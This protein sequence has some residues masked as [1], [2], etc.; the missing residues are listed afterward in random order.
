M[1]KAKIYCLALIA[2]LSAAASS[3]SDVLET[4]N[5]TDMSPGN[6]FKSE[7]DIDAA[8]T[9]IYLPCTTNWGYSDGGTGSWYNAIFNADINAPYPAAMVMTDIA[10]TYSSNRFEEFK[11]GP[12][13]GSALASC[14]NVLR[15]VARAT[16][17]I[18]RIENCQGS[19]PAV[20]ARYVAEAKT[21]RAYYMLTLLDWFG[22]VNAKL[23][24]STLMSNQIMPR[25][26]YKEYVGYIEKDL[27]DAIA[28]PFFPDKYNDDAANWGRMSKSIAWGIALRLHMH[29]KDWEKAKADAEQ[30]MGMGYSIIPEY[31]DV[32][33]KAV[34]EESIWTIPSNTASDNYY[35]TEVLPSD[36]KRGYNHLSEGYIRG[37]DS[38]YLS[39]WQVFCMRWEFYDTFDDGDVRKATIL[40]SYDTNGGEHKDRANGMAGAI[41]LKFTDTQFADYG[42]Q[43]GHPVI[44]YAEVLLSYAEA[45]NELSGPVPAALAAAGQVTDRAR[46]VIPEWAKAGREQFREWLLAERGRELYCEGQRRQDLIRHGEFIKRAA[47]RGAA[48]QEH[49]VLF[50]IPQSVVT[51][52]G[53]IIEQNEGYP[54]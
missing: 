42:I 22:P 3:C 35:I 27:E 8:V 39:G 23:D 1:R 54:K 52:A 12:S 14:Y 26:G 2:G 48:A 49:H 15:F 34:T 18:N 4:K 44:R 9:G 19:T 43:K 17:V 33:N 50:P 11:F 38:K 7:G 36:F 21:L 47:A 25:P 40:C 32:F 30:I 29:Q 37:N 20:R 46:T 31:R 45:V 28:S 51:E 16:D 10:T 5:F 13:S 6:F 24:P 53:G 41:P